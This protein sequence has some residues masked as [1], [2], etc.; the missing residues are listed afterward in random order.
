MD[1]LFG[2]I[3]KIVI[4]LSVYAIIKI[5]YLVFRII[6]NWK[7]FTKAGEKGWKTFIPLV[8]TYTE[9]KIAWSKKAFWIYML[10]SVL[11]GVGMWWYRDVYLINSDNFNKTLAAV[12]LVLTLLVAIASTVLI[13]IYYGKL[14]KAFG[15]GFGFTLGLILLEP[16]FIM[17]L[18][19]GKDEYLGTEE[20]PA[21][22][23]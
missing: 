9:F 2:L 14:S 3:A 13:F 11:T 1:A 15:H 8:N 12:I 5:I 21:I 4:A 23:A 10:L 20:H 22:K 18:G 19:F 6:A 7:I 16:I 17:I